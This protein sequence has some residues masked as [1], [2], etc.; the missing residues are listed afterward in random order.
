MNGLVRNKT[1]L[2]LIWIAVLTAACGGE[3]STH[4]H[5]AAKIGAVGMMDKLVEQG[6]DIDGKDA[7]GRTSLHW[8]VN[9]GYG[10]IAR[11]LIEKGAGTVPMA[12]GCLSSI[13]L[14]ARS[15]KVVIVR[16]GLTPGLA[17]MAD[18]S[19]TYRPG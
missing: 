7:F 5:E 10:P 17:E 4:L 13:R 19:M 8:A 18:P 1:F 6:F 14:I 15:A 12:Y 11:H 2:F 16:E 9:R 3:Q